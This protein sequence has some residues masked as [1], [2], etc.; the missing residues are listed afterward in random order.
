MEMTNRWFRVMSTRAL[1][2]QP[3]QKREYDA[4]IVGGGMVGLALARALQK[5]HSITAGLRIAVVDK[6]DFPSFQKDTRPG[7]LS[8]D[9][10]IPEARV[11]TITPA[12]VDFLKNLGV[13][14]QL[15]PPFSAAFTDM[16]VWDGNSSPTWGKYIKYSSYDIGSSEMGF[17]VENSKL[18]TALIKQI[19]ASDKDHS[20]T[21][22]SIDL[23]GNTSVEKLELPKSSLDFHGEKK[24]MNDELIDSRPAVLSLQDGSEIHARL[25]IGADGARSMI[26][27]FAGIRCMRRFYQQRAVVA[28]LE[29]LK[30]D[31]S[32][33]STAWQKFLVTGPIALLPVRNGYWNVV[34]STT[35]EMA[36]ELESMEEEN[37]AEVLN[38]AVQ[39]EEEQSMNLQ[40]RSSNAPKRPPRMARWVGNSP[41]SFPLQLRHAGTYVLPRLA[42]VGDA[43]H[44][45]HPMAGQGLNLGLA[46]AK[47]LAEVIADAIKSGTDIGDPQTLKINYQEP[48]IRANTVMIE[49]IDSLQRI[50][51]PQEGPLADLR[52][53]GLGLLN[54]VPIMKQTVMR[55][56]MFGS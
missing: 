45:I 23:L 40:N 44:S 43:A 37:F 12:S 47:V 39:F 16:Q 52:R 7:N 53:L 14:R 25:V 32:N 31:N 24:E 10:N 48:R 41:R 54:N 19:R 55:Y 9:E 50:W 42:L 8:T 34:W 49:A 33:H 51:T 22:S 11:S 56:A 29:E 46:D 28:T 21:G 6:A 30:T 17:V 36:K 2:C 35:P 18:V 38:Q 15:M 4:V 5:L 26:R 20:S 27:E 13:W 3:A 1:G